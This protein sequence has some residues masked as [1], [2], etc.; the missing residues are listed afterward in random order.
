MDELDTNELRRKWAAMNQRAAVGGAQVATLVTELTN[1]ID[2]ARRER[3]DARAE[4]RR[5]RQELDQVAQERDEAVADR[6]ELRRALAYANDYPGTEDY[7]MYLALAGRFNDWAA[8]HA[9]GYA[10]GFN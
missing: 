1:E 4:A 8:R 2:K 5:Y 7:V 3:E 9:P 6:D 10:G